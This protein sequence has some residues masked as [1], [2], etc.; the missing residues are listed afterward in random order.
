MEWINDSNLRLSLLF[1]GLFVLCG[2][3]FFFPL[4]KRDSSHLGS[5]ILMTLTLLVTNVIF[6]S[7][8]LFLSKWSEENNIGLFRMLQVNDVLVVLISIVFLDFWAAYVSHFLFHKFGWLWKFHS[9]HHSDTMVDVTTAFRQHPI[10]SIFRMTFHISG[11]ILLGIPIWVLLIYLT[12]SALNAQLEHS[13]LRLP[14]RLDK[15]LQYVFVT[16]NMHKVHHSKDQ[17]ETDSNYSNIFSVWDRIFST[18]KTR[19]QYNTISYG[20]DYLENSKTFSFWQL[21]KLPF[22]K[23]N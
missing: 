1:I 20:L 15:I 18:Y 21:I 16:P 8:T 14:S 19:R 4:V 7:L 2:L 10:E 23:S 13:N 11:M 6:S 3:E 9:V 22:K 12:L 17:H 5:N